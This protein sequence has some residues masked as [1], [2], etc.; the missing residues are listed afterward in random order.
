MVISFLY[1]AFCNLLYHNQ[2]RPSNVSY[3]YGTQIFKLDWVM[4]SVIILAVLAALLYQLI[5]VWKSGFLNGGNGRQSCFADA[6]D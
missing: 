6:A 2:L 3:R 4:L 1:V 5:L